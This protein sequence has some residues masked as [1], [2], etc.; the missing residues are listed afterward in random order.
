MLTRAQTGNLKPRQIF[1]LEHSVIPTNPTGVTQAVKYSAWRQAMSTEFEALQRQGTWLL[2]PPEPH[3]NVLGCKWLFKTKFNSNGSIAR[4]KARLVAQ[5]FKQEHGLDYYETFSPVAKFATIRVFL[6][7]TV[8]HKW[9]LLQLDMS[10]AF[11]HGAL[12]EQVFMKQPA[13]F[14][15]SQFPHHVC[16]LKKAIYGLKQS[17]RQW[18]ETLSSYLLSYGFT[19]S[20][21]DPSL[22]IYNRDTTQLYILI[23][24][25]DILLTG[26]SDAAISTLFRALQTKF[27][28]NNLGKL[29][30]F[31]GLQATHTAYGIH[32]N[33][34]H[35][36]TEV[37]HKAAMSDCKP[38]LTPLPTVLPSS[39]SN[40]QPFERPEFYR[41]IVGSLQY[42][43]LTRPDL[44]F[45]VHFLCKYMHQPQLLH[46][47][48]LKRVLRYIKGTIQLGLPIRQDSL[49]LTSFADS[50][51]ASDKIDRKS[52]TGYCA[53]LGSTLVSWSVKKQ[54]S[55]ARSSTEAEY[56]AVSTAACE[57]IWLRR[58]LSEFKALSPAPTQLYCDNVSALALANNPI[59]HARTKHIEIDFHFIRD[60]IRSNQISVHHIS[61]I[62]QPAD[63]FT[64][65]LPAARF[66]LLRDKLR[67]QSPSLP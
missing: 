6:T 54:T 9:T 58:L 64:K 42:L 40:D 8:S 36:A 63:I 39:D 41:Q 24:V 53:F 16:L 55:V 44:L 1:D 3:Q 57:V 2:V 17:P 47:Q 43:T 21:A 46:F 35:Y 66:V 38:V 48:L 22:L 7:V 19:T 33:Q 62:D 25:D 60:C 27:K 49:H 11:L 30:Q 23:Y 31:L 26:N 28:M 32:L 10:N 13:G 4:Y 45:A 15:D 52:V 67:I 37:L 5:G 29:N 51:W 34:T 12:Q 65:S 18:F 61:T 20:T 50:D 14:V 56:R 59:F